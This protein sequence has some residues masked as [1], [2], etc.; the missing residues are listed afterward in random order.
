MKSVNL[1]GY[2]AEDKRDT[3][4]VV[5]GLEAFGDKL[6]F[7]SNG[8]GNGFDVWDC[9]CVRAGGESIKGF[10][11]FSGVLRLPETI[12]YAD[13]TKVTLLGT[14]VGVSADND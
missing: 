7:K 3:L 14:E 4:G 5:V 6:L 13:I 8:G 12:G 2:D 9:V 10:V 11:V 1:N